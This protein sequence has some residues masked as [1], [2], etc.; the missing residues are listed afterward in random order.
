MDPQNFKIPS[1]F[2]FP[3]IKLVSW[4]KTWKRNRDNFRDGFPLALVLGVIQLPPPGVFF[5]AKSPRGR[6][7]RLL[8]GLPTTATWTVT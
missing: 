7:G 1:F 2:F 8:Q 5:A 3:G 4:K 6:S